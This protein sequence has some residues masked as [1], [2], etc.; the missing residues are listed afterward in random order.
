MSRSLSSGLQECTVQAVFFSVKYVICW[1]FERRLLSWLWPCPT[2][3]IHGRGHAQQAAFMAMAMHNRLLPWPCTTGYFH[4]HVQRVAF[5]ALAMHNRLL[6]WLA[7]C[8][9]SLQLW[10]PDCKETSWG[11]LR[12][13]LTLILGWSVEEENKTKNKPVIN[14]WDAVFRSRRQIKSNQG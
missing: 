1:S 5:M 11:F 7:L 6:S 8:G 12:Y 13:C 10:F 9:F 3:C 4:G 14:C 2:G